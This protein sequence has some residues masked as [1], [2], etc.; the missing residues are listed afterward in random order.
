M[1]QTT[2]DAL[3]RGVHHIGLTVPDLAATRAF[4]TDTLGYNQVGEIFDYPAVFLSDG[5]VMITLWQ[6]ADPVNATPFDRQNNIGLH[7]FALIVEDGAALDAMHERVRNSDG[8]RIEFAPEPLG[9]GPTR[10]MMC[11][12]PGGI[13]LEFIAPAT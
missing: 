6:A 9:G 7:H 10:H 5:H 3:T 1:N 13:R 2:T 12:I 11:Y 4:F 8:T